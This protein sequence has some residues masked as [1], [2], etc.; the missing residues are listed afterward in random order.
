MSIIVVEVR[1]RI[2]LLALGTP[3]GSPL[4]G[5]ED[6]PSSVALIVPL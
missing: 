1:V 3:L 2:G 4:I 5:G 6:E